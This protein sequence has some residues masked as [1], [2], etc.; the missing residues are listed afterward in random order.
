LPSERES[1]LASFC[2]AKPAFVL[3]ELENGQPRCALHGCT[4]SLYKV[5]SEARKKKKKKKKKKKR[6]RD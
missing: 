4:K 5:Q 2:N 3:L 6:R 1:V